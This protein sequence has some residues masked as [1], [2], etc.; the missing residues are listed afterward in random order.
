MGQNKGPTCG[1]IMVP[2]VIIL[3]L[4]L[5]VACILG[6]AQNAP[7]I[8]MYFPT[9]TPAPTWTPL[10]SPT[11]IPPT[12]TVILRCDTTGKA[13]APGQ[14]VADGTIWEGTY[15]NGNRYRFECKVSL[16]GIQETFLGKISTPT[17][18]P[19]PG[20][21]LPTTC[22]AKRFIGIDAVVLPGHQIIAR[23]A[24]PG[25]PANAPAQYYLFTCRPD[26]AAVDSGG[27]I[28]EYQVTDPSLL[29]H[30]EGP[31]PGKGGGWWAEPN[32][33]IPGTDS[34]TYYCDGAG[35]WYD[36]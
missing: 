12:P 30:C 31:P 34:R 16:G 32:I 15:P 33:P 2:L 20:P 22:N 23:Y 10:P 26:I 14:T 35:N 6:L 5:V 11:P 8:A 21:V 7:L 24:P 18:T 17:Q 1:E 28:L 19:R 36:P 27:W 29:G 4:A 3:A 25:S 13:E 9:A